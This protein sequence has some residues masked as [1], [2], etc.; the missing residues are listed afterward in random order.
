MAADGRLRELQRLL[1]RFPTVGW[2]LLQQYVAEDCVGDFSYKPRW[3]RGSMDYGDV[4][5]V[6]H[7]EIQAAVNLLLSR[8]HYEV[9]QLTD[10]VEHLKDLIPVDREKVFQLIRC[11]QETEGTDEAAERVRSALRRWG[12]RDTSERSVGGAGAL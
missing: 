5:A 6:S 9:N 2:Q 8:P 12:P 7:E 11:W 4:Q 1:E 10:L 3:R